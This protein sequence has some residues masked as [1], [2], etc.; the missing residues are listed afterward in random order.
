MIMITKI[1]NV[2]VEV[3]LTT[4]DL[5]ILFCN[6]NSEEQAKFFNTIATEV[7]AWEHPFCFQLSYISSEPLLTKEAREVMEQIGEYSK[8]FYEN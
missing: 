1:V 3:E 8:E 7:A 2:D 4:E 6:L 5:A